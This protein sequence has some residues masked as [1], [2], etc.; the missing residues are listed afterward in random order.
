[1]KVLH[2]ASEL[3]PLIKTGGLADVL[4]ALPPALAELGVDT[5]VLVPGY[6]PVT[7]AV[8]DG[9]AVWTDRFL[10]GGG[11]ARLRCVRA[12]AV[13]V[14][15][16]VLDCPGH[17]DRPGNPYLDF[18][19]KDWTDNEQRF[20]ALSWIAARLGQGLDPDWR[21]DIVHAHDWQAGLAPAY[22]ALDGGPRPSTVLT[23][24]NLAY[25][26]LFPYAAVERLGLPAEAFRYDALEFYGQLGFLKAGLSYADRITTV[27][28][29][30]AK[31]IQAEEQGCGLDALL[32]HRAAD[33]V[34]IVNGVDYGVWDPSSDPHLPS[35]YSARD[36]KGKAAAKAALQKAMGLPDAPDAP[37]I[38]VVSRLNVH[39]GLDLMLAALP[40]LIR[41]GGQLVLLGSGDAD[42]E[43][44]FQAMARKAPDSVGVRIGYDE[45]LSH[46]I[47]GGSDV[48]AVPSRSEPCGLTQLYALRYGA[49]PLVRRAGG[50]ADTVVDSTA[51]AIDKGK[52]TGFVFRAASAAALSRAIGRA[53]DLYADKQTWAG[54]QQTAMAQD[55]GWPAAARNYQ[56]L[57]REMLA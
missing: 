21:P 22:L 40:T 54:I 1:M 39:K 31:E 57:Y 10:F 2:V 51:S 48:I 6:P 30:Y 29:T 53:C 56:A 42:L 3:Y 45:A 26:G 8:R 5:R 35:P 46:L 50:L 36:L 49:L 17:Y 18:D 24:H 47:Q 33:L 43:E 20:G 14:P 12:K 16:Y 23:I 25:Q 7:A 34:G 32:R 38:G 4:G 28:R 55:F 52:A 13:A 11:E 44:G 27:S 41:A 19:G 37:V 15:L 9:K